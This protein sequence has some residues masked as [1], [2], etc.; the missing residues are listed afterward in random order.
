MHEFVPNSF[1]LFGLRA[2]CV[3]YEI[4]AYEQLNTV[5]F[6]ERARWICC[7]NFE[8]FGS[9]EIPFINSNFASNQCFFFRFTECSSFS[10]IEINEN[11]RFGRTT[12]LSS[13]DQIVMCS[14]VCEQRVDF[15]AES[16]SSIF[17]NFQSY[18]L[19]HKQPI[20][21]QTHMH[22]DRQTFMYKI[23]SC[24]LNVINIRWRFSIFIS[25]ALQMG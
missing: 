25:A 20:E 8:T 11:L 15:P 2:E 10:G 16:F 14:W 12:L 4:S 1:N 24:I 22:A 13:S 5:R 18:A 6:S 19:T 7:S 9:V 21:T 3:F 23:C 17:L